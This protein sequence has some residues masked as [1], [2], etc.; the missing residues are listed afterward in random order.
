MNSNPFLT[1]IMFEP[2][3]CQNNLFSVVADIDPIMS[4]HYMVYSR[5][6]LPSIAD[7]DFQNAL[8]FLN[9]TF[10]LKA[11]RPYAYFERGRASFCTSMQGV[12]HGH[13]H[14]V[15]QFT[16]N[17]ADLF[18]YGMVETYDSLSEAYRH[19]VKDR[20]FL[21]WGNL[22]MEGYLINGVEYIPKRAIRNTIRAYHDGQRYSSYRNAEISR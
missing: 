9:D 19:V 13:G 6:W 15:P 8:D 10:L 14:L 21:I 12:Q 3:L 17:M 16:E 1:K 7:C 2:Q 20:Q 22:N 4:G 18:P 11:G 5:Q